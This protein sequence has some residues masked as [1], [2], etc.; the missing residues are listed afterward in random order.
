MHAT[1]HNG[2]SMIILAAV[3]NAKQSPVRL[4]P[5]FNR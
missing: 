4:L 5:P 3:W 2:E 1:F